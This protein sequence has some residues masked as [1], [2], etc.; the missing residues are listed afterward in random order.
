MSNYAK[1]DNRTQ[2]YQDNFPGSDLTLTPDTM[3]VVLH[4]T[5]GRTWPGYEGGATAPNYTH[6][7]GLV[8]ISRPAW[9]AHFP[10]EKS[11][12]ALR[13]LSGGVETNTLNAEQ[14]ELIGTCDPKHRRSW[15][16]RGTKFAGKD[17]VYWPD[18]TEAQMKEVAAFLADMHRR[19]GLR[20]RAPAQ[21]IAYPASFGATNTRLTFAEWRNVTGVIGHQH[22]PENAH[23]DP[24]NINVIRILEL[25]RAMVT[26]VTPPA[27]T[28]LHMVQAS[29][30]TFDSPEQKKIDVARIF[31]RAKTR[32]AAWVCG[33][34]AFST[35]GTLDNLLTD[36]SEELGFRFIHPA[37]DSWIAVN[38]KFYVPGTFE[39]HWEKVVEGGDLHRDLGV[40]A[41]TVTNKDLGKLTVIS[42]HLLKKSV[43]GSAEKNK[44]VLAATAKFARAAAE[45]SDLVFYHGDQNMND[46][47]VDTFMGYPFIS[48]QDELKRWESTGHGPIDMIARWK[49]DT[50]PKPK[51]V[52]VLDDG[53]FFLHMDHY[54][55]EAGYTVRHL[56]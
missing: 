39:A 20:L 41:A 33:T 52:R 7:P 12:R 13:N 54:V 24:G 26:V 22:V 28:V 36:K 45:G 32:G 49:G 38:K 43:E 31:H 44:K 8:G 29:M 17:Y 1:A 11:S 3:V 53:E 46:R 18:A 55:V 23:G 42:Q 19:H 34:E 5:E 51:Y 10:D 25:A 6:M 21:F 4:T 16:G 47:L 14:V 40:L 2:W 50:R 27:E 15:D 37:G 9:R 56:R 35:K 48:I 30:E